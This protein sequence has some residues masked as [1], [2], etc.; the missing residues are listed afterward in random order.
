MRAAQFGFQR[1]A[2]GLARAHRRLEHLDAV[3]ADA[4]GVIHR[5]LGVLQHF[6]AYGAD[7]PSASASPID[8]VRKISRSLKV[9]GARSARRM[10]SAKAMMR[11]GSRSDRQDQRELIAGKPRQRI[12]RLQQPA[13]PARQRQ[14]DRVADRD[15]DG[16]VDLLEAIEIDDHHRR[17]DRRIGLGE[18]QH[19]LRAGRGTAGGSAGR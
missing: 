16:I 7:W 6:L 1:Q 19:G 17:P 8:A 11:P 15:A 3:A 4:L 9:I 2:V 5:K 12:L 18:A 14:Q 10:F 13:E